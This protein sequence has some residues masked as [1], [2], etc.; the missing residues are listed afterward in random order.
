M[1]QDKI[2]YAINNLRTRI[3]R[4]LLTTSGIAIAV[5]TVAIL[6]SLGLG[7]FI[8][9]NEQFA[10]LGGDKLFVQ[11]KGFGPAGDQNLAGL[12]KKDA[13]FVERVVGIEQAYGVLFESIQIEYK[14]TT[15]YLYGIGIP[16]DQYQ[17]LIQESFL[18][19]IHEG[20]FLRQGDDNKV[21]LGYAYTQPNTVF[22]RRVNLRDN[23]VINGKKFEVVGFYK[24]L[25]NPIDDRHVYFTENALRDLLGKPE[26]ITMILAKIAPN[27]DNEKIAST[28]ERRL[29][30]NLGQKEG[31]ET[32]TVQTAEQLIQSFNAVLSI[33]IVFI[34]AVGL[35]SLIVGSINIMNTMYTAVL[36]RTQEIGTIKSIGGRNS[37]IL[38]I[39]ML[40]SSI[41]GL[42]G[43]TAGIIGAYLITLS[44]A[45]IV[46]GLGFGVL[47]H[48]FPLWLVGSG[49]LFAVIMGIISGLLPSL[50]ASKQKPV[51]A[52]R[53]E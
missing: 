16:T 48:Y 12:Q 49:I 26:A 20:R 43:G 22:P 42:L 25:G 17:K 9:I 29:R 24:E 46:Q 36:E 4:T 8:G 31:E 13:R 7:L 35:I 38:L 50:Q 23:V 3:L 6:L 32:F 14:G 39:F 11:A 30:T 44:V 27:Q 2:R 15:K 51:E 53:Y 5:A 19:K 47:Q 40:E 52:L 37:D 41:I 28:I 21:T 10:E 1:I 33:L 45:S 34:V 18:L